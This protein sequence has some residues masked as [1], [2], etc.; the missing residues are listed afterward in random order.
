MKVKN[1]KIPFGLIVLSL[2][3]LFSVIMGKIAIL[4]MYE[5]SDISHTELPSSVI[6]TSDNK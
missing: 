4:A 2:L 5:K 1:H 6:I 3:L